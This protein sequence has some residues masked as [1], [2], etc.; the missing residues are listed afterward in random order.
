MFNLQ[1]K[2]NALRVCVLAVLLYVP[3][4]SQALPHDDNHVA[5][6]NQPTARV[7]AERECQPSAY[8]NRWADSVGDQ[9]VRDCYS[10]FMNCMSDCRGDA[11]CEFSCATTHGFC[12]YTCN[13]ATRG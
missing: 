4:M 1:G 12:F 3:L 7:L 11:W 10:W 9:C 2:V 5:L 6:D 8:P 13:A